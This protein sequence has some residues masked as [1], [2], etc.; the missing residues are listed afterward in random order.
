MSHFETK[1]Q[2]RPQKDLFLQKDILNIMSLSGFILD[3]NNAILILT[4]ESKQ[5]IWLSWRS[6]LKL[7]FKY[8]QHKYA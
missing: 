8:F 5:Y 6:L 7:L 2:R 1:V 3:F 4:T